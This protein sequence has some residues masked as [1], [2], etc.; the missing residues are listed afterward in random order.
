MRL[1]T[2]PFPPPRAGT[3]ACRPPSHRRAGVPG[4]LNW[5]RGRSRPT[6]GDRSRLA[7]DEPKTVQATS[8]RAGRIE[9]RQLAAAQ[10]DGLAVQAAAAL[11][12]ITNAGRIDR[13]QE[14]GA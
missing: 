2:W 1:R 3:R 12:P 4:Q 5:M 11:D 6:D 13:H 9:R 8:L 10:E 7:G 14:A